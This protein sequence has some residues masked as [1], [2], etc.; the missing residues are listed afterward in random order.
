MTERHFIPIPPGR[1]ETHPFC[2]IA[3]GKGNAGHGVRNNG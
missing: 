2:A 1:A 3:D